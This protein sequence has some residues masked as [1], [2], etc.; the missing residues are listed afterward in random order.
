MKEYEKNEKN[1]FNPFRRTFLSQEDEI[2]DELEAVQTLLKILDSRQLV[3]QIG[4]LQSVAWSLVKDFRFEK[5]FRVRLS[6]PIKIA[7]AQ[8]KTKQLLKTE[9]EDDLKK[10][11]QKFLSKIQSL[12]EL[13]VTNILIPSNGKTRRVSLTSLE[14]NIYAARSIEQLQSYF[15]R[16]FLGRDNPFRLSD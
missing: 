11:K 8:E 6:E 3:Q 7:K 5:P 10:M 1:I 13:G 16:L 15:V 14:G 4:E 2:K 9:W 12:Y